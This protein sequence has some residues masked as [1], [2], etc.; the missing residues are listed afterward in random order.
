MTFVQESL[1]AARTKGE[2]NDLG[3][4]VGHPVAKVTITLQDVFYNPAFAVLC[5]VPCTYKGEAVFGASSAQGMASKENPNAAGAFFA[6]PSQMAAGTQVMLLF[7][8]RD[9]RKVTVLSARP[10]IP[11]VP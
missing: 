4:S 6:M 9:E 5:D 2:A 10:Y 1:E 8:S 11:P 3:R 7:E